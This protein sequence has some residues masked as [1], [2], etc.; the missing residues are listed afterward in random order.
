LPSHVPSDTVSPT[1]AASPGATANAPK[2]PKPPKSATP[3]VATGP[4]L[5][6][7]TVSKF[8][9]QVDR[10]V[11]GQPAQGHVTIKNEGSADALQF[12]LGITISDAESGGGGGFQPITVDGLAAGES[13]QVS[14]NI[15]PPA[16]GHFT[17]TATADSRNAIVES[18]EDD[19]TLTLEATAVV[20]PN[21]S[22]FDAPFIVKQL[23]GETGYRMAFNY[24][25]S[26]PV[27]ITTPFENS[28]TWSSSVESGT[29]QSESCCSTSHG[30]DWGSGAQSFSQPGPYNF[31]QAGTYTV[32]VTL[33]AKNVVEE[34]DET[35]NTQSYTVTVNQ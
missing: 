7:L 26:G 30:M 27:T 33:D 35:D 13:V 1:A 6:N 21:I 17:Y 29:F 9:T 8:T 23:D 28:F 22:F 16:A 19:N 5:P 14:V 12:D 34:S 15:S 31:P 18:S 32:V 20:L 3:A 2:T 10:V 25:N 4:A 24:T 11:V